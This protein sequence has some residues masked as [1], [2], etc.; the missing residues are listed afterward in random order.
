MSVYI[1]IFV[2][3][4]III[5]IALGIVYMTPKNYFSMFI[6]GKEY[7]VTP[8]V[9]GEPSS[10]IN[11]SSPLTFVQMKSQNK[12]DPNNAFFVNSKG[13]K[14]IDLA[15][16]NGVYSANSDLLPPV[17]KDTLPFIS[18]AKGIYKITTDRDG[19]KILSGLNDG[20]LLQ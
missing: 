3:L 10:L 18:S 13:L 14:I 4:I 15:F 7:K 19:I 8:L 12:I 5:G 6:D 1:I 17:G 11:V 16:N 9:F 2:V 20:V